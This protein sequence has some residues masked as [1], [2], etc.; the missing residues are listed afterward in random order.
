MTETMKK[1]IPNA[2]TSMNLVFGMCSIIFTFEGDVYMGA[3]CIFLALVADGLDGRI[4]RFFGVSSELGK[5][6]DSLC[7]LC[8][9]GV[10]PAVLAYRFCLS[11]FGVLGWCVAI[12]FALCGMLRLARFNVN[13]DKIHGYFM[14]LAIPAG[15][16][17]VSGTTL[18]F[19]ALSLPLADYGYTYPATMTIVSYLMISRVH[20]PD[21][22]GAGEKIFP[23]AKVAAVIIFAAI[24]FL[25]REALPYALLAAF[26]CSYAIFGIVNSLC[27][28]FAGGK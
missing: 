6:M 19:S 11:G 3:V 12:L 26:F 23:L 22:K 25:G 2:C 1:I 28:L 9:F 14:G 24:A 17:V 4:A 20:Y 10:A 18:L 15:A 13:T 21:F 16:C 27:A 5:E 8:S 7:D